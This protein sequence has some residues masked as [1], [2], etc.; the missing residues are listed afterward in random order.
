LEHFGW[1]CAYCGA[2]PFTDLDHF[3][4]LATGGGTTA[5]NCV[6]ACAACNNLKRATDPAQPPL[7][8]IYAEAVERVRRYLRDPRRRV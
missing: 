2:Q 5:D 4:A 8:L 6:P 7:A 3:V 1:R